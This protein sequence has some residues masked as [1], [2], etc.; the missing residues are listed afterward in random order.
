MIQRASSIQVKLA[1]APHVRGAS[2]RFETISVSIDVVKGFPR[3]TRELGEMMLLRERDHTG[4][5]MRERRPVS[6]LNDL[7]LPG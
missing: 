4:D 5:R 2:K 6:P 3:G 1:S 7:P